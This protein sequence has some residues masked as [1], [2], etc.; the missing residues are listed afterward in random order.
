M[1]CCA[2]SSPAWLLTASHSQGSSQATSL[3]VLTRWLVGGDG[4][5][6]RECIPASCS[7][8]SGN[9]QLVNSCKPHFAI[10]CRLRGRAHGRPAPVRSLS[11]LPA[12]I[13][14]VNADE[15]RR[16]CVRRLPAVPLVQAWY[17]FVLTAML[18]FLVVTIVRWTRT[19]SSPVYIRNL[20][21]ALW[22]I[23]PIAG[24]IVF[25]LI[26]TPWERRCGGHM[27]PAV[28]VAVWLMAAFPGASVL[29]YL[30]AQLAGSLV[31]V[32]LGRLLWGP[33]VSGP[34]VGFAAVRP[35]PGWSA[36][37]VFLAEAG[38]II[39][40]TLAVGFLLT[41][42][43]FAR[44]LPHTV[45]VCIALTIVILGPLSGGSSNPARQ[46][47]PVILSGNRVDLAVYLVA[48]IVGALLGASVHHLLYRRFQ[49]RQPLTYRLSGQAAVRASSE[50]SVV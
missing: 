19:P 33:A 30:A 6:A 47:G 22:L 26:M 40:L 31:G 42:P 2:Y 23:G 17:E 35:A 10:P 28:T 43:A 8:P 18:L 7:I 1:R 15:V 32:T 20:H 48:P 38:C 3:E 4:D 49:T 37:V 5:L 9:C 46:F 36:S 41:Y 11:A 25:G 44:W 14:A 24:L 45:S 21:H 39:V 13:N 50:T 27:N 16:E 12:C 29:P 34:A